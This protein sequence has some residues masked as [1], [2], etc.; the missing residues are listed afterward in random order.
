MCAGQG[1]WP[2]FC[3]GPSI[4]HICCATCTHLH[5]LDP[6]VAVH[7]FL[8]KG[9]LALAVAEPDVGARVPDVRVVCIFNI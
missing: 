8:K 1:G 6:A 4:W 2:E 9:L 5:C 3:G 7:V